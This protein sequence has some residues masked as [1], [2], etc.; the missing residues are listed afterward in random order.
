[1]RKRSGFVINLYLKDGAFTA[2]KRD[3]K[4]VFESGVLSIEGIRNGYPFLSKIVYK[5]GKGLD[6]RDEP[7]ATKSLL[8]TPLIPPLG[9]LFIEDRMNLCGFEGLQNLV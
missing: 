9:V 1:M 2:V 4:G 6:L 8:F 3:A 7:L 5:K